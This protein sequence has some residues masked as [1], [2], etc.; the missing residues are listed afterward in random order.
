MSISDCRLDDVRRRALHH[1]HVGVVLPQ[2]SADVERGVV[3]ADRPRPSCRGT[4]PGPGARTGVVLVAAEDVLAGR[5]RASGPCRTCRSRTPAASGRSVSGPPSRSTSTV[6]SSV[7]SDQVAER[8]GRCSTSTAPPSPSCTSPASRRSCPWARTPASSPG[9]AGTAGGR[10]RPGRAGRATCSGC[11]TGRRAAGA[12][13][14]TRA[15]TPSWRSRAP[16]A[17][18]PCPPPITT[19]YGCA[20]AAEALGLVLPLLLPGP[21]ALARAVLDALRP[22][23]AARLLE[24]LELAQGGQQRPRSP[25]SSLRRRCPCRGRPPSRT[26][27][28]PRPRRRP[29]RPLGLREAGR[30]DAVEGGAKQVGDTVAALDG[31]DV[32]GEGDQVAPVARRRRTARWR[33]GRRG[34]RSAA[35]NA[36]S[37]S[38]TRPAADDWSEAPASTVWVMA[39]AQHPRLRRA[40]GLQALHVAAVTRGRLSS[41]H[42]AAGARQALGDYSAIRPGTDLSQHARDLLRVHDAVIGGGRARRTARGRW[43]SGPGRG[44]WASGL[45]PDSQQPRDPMWFEDVERRRRDVA[46]SLIIADLPGAG[47]RGRRLALPD[48]GDRR[49]RRRSCGARARPRVRRR[50]TTWASPRA[51]LD[52]AH[53]RHQRDRHRPGRGRAGAAVLGRALRAG[54]ARL[55][56]HRPPDPRPAHRRAARHRRRQRSGAHPAPGHRGAGRD[57]GPAGRGATCGGTTQSGWNGCAARPSTCSAAAQRAAA[58]RRRPRLG[59]PPRRASPP[60]TGSGRPGTAPLWP[61]PGW[62]SAC[63]NAWPRAGSCGRP[64]APARDPPPST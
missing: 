60:A 27:S 32:P 57:R 50:P 31:G 41:A 52:R 34:P 4:P 12:C 19:T 51:P 46:R 44:C 64:A 55:V 58:D 2:R 43:S 36:A 5:S 33:P 21:P 39:T 3:R 48:G 45:D 25:S 18:P 23:R 61:Y 16:R 26:R 54:P 63:P 49:R 8:G 24:P 35:S 38:S 6:H 37:Q 30:V 10:T 7:S 13:R 28:R 53:G 29:R 42:A 56:L 47:Q 59:R 9:T 20:R 40:T 17:M 1:R 15:G 22:V 62:G 14:S 11:A